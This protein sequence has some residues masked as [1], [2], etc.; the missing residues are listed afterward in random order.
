VKIKLR[1]RIKQTHFWAGSKKKIEFGPGQLYIKNMKEIKI[2]SRKI[3]LEHK[4]ETDPKSAITNLSKIIE[5]TE[6]KYLRSA[7]AYSSAL[8]FL[9]LMF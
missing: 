5:K 4:F 9:L 6:Y 2:S 3:S 7:Q 1:V 8:T